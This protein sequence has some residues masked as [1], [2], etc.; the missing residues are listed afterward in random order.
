ML[1][2]ALEIEYFDSHLVRI[3]QILEENGESDNTIVVVTA[4]NGMPFPRRKGLEYEYSNHL[5]LAIMWSKGIKNPGREEK[6]YINFIDLAPI[7]LEVAGIKWET[8]GMV[9]S[10]GKSLTDIF[11]NKPKRD[12]SSIMLGQERHDYGRP[13][14]QGYPIRSIIQEGFLYLYDFKLEI[15]PL[16]N[17]EPGYLNAD[18]GPTKTNILNM[19]RSNTDRSF[20]S[21]CFGKHPQEEMYQINVDRKCLV[22]LAKTVVY[23][24]IKL[25]LKKKLFDTLMEQQD[26]RV[27]GN[28]DIF[29]KYPFNMESSTN[30]YERY[31]N[32]EIKKYQ[33]D[34]VNSGDYE[35]TIPY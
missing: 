29:D 25:K 17:P 15:L 11:Y 10:P 24:E 22:N 8:S 34:W 32:V 27:L 2:Y 33:T 4:D 31:M 30:I 26:P 6:S 3:L 28:G 9:E 12:R 5:P 16:E 1:D 23:N 20:W 21:I 7:F 19:W 14:N 13:K 35:K 18:G